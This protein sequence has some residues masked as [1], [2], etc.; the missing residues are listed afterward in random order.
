M[1]SRDLSLDLA[2]Y[3]FSNKFLAKEIYKFK[4][5]IFFSIS[6]AFFLEDL[7]FRFSLLSSLF[8]SYE[9]SPYSLLLSYSIRVAFC[10][11]VSR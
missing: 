1:K 9:F 6:P 2:F 11:K 10:F 7:L 8:W 5:A 3:R 4:D